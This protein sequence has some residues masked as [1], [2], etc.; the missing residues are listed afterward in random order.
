I[1]SLQ[2]LW[3]S[4]GGSSIL[5]LRHCSTTPIPTFDYK[6]ANIVLCFVM[7]HIG[8]YLYRTTIAWVFCF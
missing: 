4:K 1:Q 3:L 8:N 5:R 7:L 2:L 6:I